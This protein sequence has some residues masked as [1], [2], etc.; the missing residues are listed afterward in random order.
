M[1]CLPPPLARLV[2]LVMLLASACTPRPSGPPGD[3]NLLFKD[4]FANVD[5]GW[6]R[7]TGAEGAV[8]YAEGQYQIRVDEPNIYLW[9]TP[10]LDLTDSALEA[11]TIY[12]AGPANN[13]FGLICRF[14][15]TDG[16]KNFYFF[17]I[18]S[19]GYYVAGK[20]VRDKKTYLSAPDFQS[21]A[22]I[23]KDLATV[24]HLSA[25]CA[26]NNMAF[27]VNGV[28]LGQFQDDELKHGGFGLIVGAYDEGEVE[29]R[30]DNV[31]VRKP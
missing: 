2:A 22:A 23:K 6:D 17:F 11:D 4:D 15:Q 30:F 5:S 10:G 21:S 1:L 24:N 14:T 20:V 16:K 29:I 12:A 26:E 3:P 19:D 28:A 8:G 9:G 7:Y 13:E 25:T 27:A 18:S 31:T